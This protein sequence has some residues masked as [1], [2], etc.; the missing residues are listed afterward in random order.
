MVPLLASEGSLA[1]EGF[2]VFIRGWRKIEGDVVSS[3][4]SCEGAFF[5]LEGRQWRMSALT[6]QLLCAVKDLVRA[7][8]NAPGEKTNQLGWAAIRKAAKAAGA[9]FD[10]FLDKTVVLRPDTLRLRLHKSPEAGLHVIEVIPQFEDQPPGW[11]RLIAC[12]QYRIIMQ[13]RRPMAALPMC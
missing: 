7:Q 13:F 12:R 6:W 9:V 1:D 3:T 4:L 5:M 2:K 10:G 11:I 8:R